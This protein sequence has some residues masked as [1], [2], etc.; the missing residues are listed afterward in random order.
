MPARVPAGQRPGGQPVQQHRHPDG[1]PD[2]DRH[3]GAVG[4]RQVLQGDDREHDGGQPAR[5]EP[6]DEQDPVPRRARADQAEG[7]G[8][9]ADHREAQQR[10][11]HRPPR[12]LGQ[13]RGQ[14]EQAEQEPH[15]QPEQLAELMAELHGEL[16]GRVV[17]QRV[18]EGQAGHEGR[19]EAVS[20]D[21]N[22]AEV[23]EQDQ[24]E[25]PERNLGALR[26]AAVQRRAKQPPAPAAD[27]RPHHQGDGQ[28]D[29]RGD[30]GVPEGLALLLGDRDGDEEQHDR[31]GQPVVDPTLD[32]DRLA[33]AARD[34]LVGD[35]RGA[36]RGV[37]RGQ[38]RGDHR[39]DGPAQAGQ[40]RHPEGPAQGHGQ[41]QADPEQPGRLLPGGAEEAEAHARGVAEEHQGQG[42][43]DQQLERLG[44]E[45]HLQ[46]GVATGAE[47]K[48]QHHQQDRG[49]DAH[50]AQA[51]RDDDPEQ[52]RAQHHH[53]RDHGAPP[54]TGPGGPSGEV[55]TVE[56]TRCLT[57]V[58]V[59]PR[60]GGGRRAARHGRARD[61]GR[62]PFH[63]CAES[64]GTPAIA[65]PWTS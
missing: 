34:P 57:E 5:A 62:L 26:Q 40:Q 12:G 13:R 16:L 20:P 25:H 18:A 65:G 29:Q 14:Q 52:D 31:G 39:H 42:H 2:H 33:G 46:Q 47:E 37:R 8:H 45:V 43:L 63:P 38:R 56:G 61:R 64:W 7:H 23:G 49:G 6:T 19:H 51:P 60:C 28:L 3:R 24:A 32:V 11:E 41:G 36:Q 17:G 1:H 59:P 9:H 55:C 15:H 44:V 53:D 30:D 54:P 10:I 58:A 27:Q 50:P 21:Q 4:R 48:P 35:H 22:R